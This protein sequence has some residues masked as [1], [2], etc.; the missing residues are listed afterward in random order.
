MPQPADQNST[1]RIR[2]NLEGITL[3]ADQ[4]SDLPLGTV[5]VH[6]ITG[7]VTTVEEFYLSIPLEM[8]PAMPEN[9]P[10]MWGLPR[11]AHD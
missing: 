11:S 6:S 7:Q 8:A 9:G 2:L 5:V 4:L 3:T 10:T 1:D